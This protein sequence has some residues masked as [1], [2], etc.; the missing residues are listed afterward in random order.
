MRF[1]CLD[2]N[3][4]AIQ[5]GQVYDSTVGLNWFLNPNMKVQL[6]YILEHRDAPQNVVQGWINGVGVRGAYDF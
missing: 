4:K 3:D 5:G 6:N 1:S 2:L